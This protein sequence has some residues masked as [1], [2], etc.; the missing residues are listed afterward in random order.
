MEGIDAAGVRK[1]LD[2]PR[3]RYSIPLIVSAGT[4]Y[5]RSMNEVLE[6]DDVGMSH[7]DDGNFSP[8]YKLDEVVFGNTFGLACDLE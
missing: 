2:I 8:R 3:G 4:P 1:V 6:T 5:R 7:G